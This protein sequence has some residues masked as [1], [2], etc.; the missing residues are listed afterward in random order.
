[1]K[2]TLPF[3]FLGCFLVY[4]IG[5]KA[6]VPDQKLLWN[7]GVTDGTSAEFALSPD[8]YKDFV[9]EGFGG[10]HRYYVVGESS[11]EKDFPYVLPGPRDDFG[12]YGYWAGLALNKLPVYFEL[13]KLPDTGTCTLQ[14]DII[15]TS[16]EQAP[17]LRSTINGTDYDHQLEKGTSQSPENR[18]DNLQRISLDLPVSLLREGIN[19]IVFQN[20]T[21]HWCAFDAIGFYGPETMQIGIPGRTLLHSVDFARR[22]LEKGGSQILPLQ[23][24]L[25]HSGKKA[26]IRAV[27][28]GA[29]RE[30]E[31]EAGHSV[32]EFEFPG[33]KNTRQS[34]VQIFVDGKL[35]YDVLRERRPQ[36]VVTPVDYV[37]QFMGTSGSRWM[38]APGP[39]MPMGMVKIAPDN[40]D[41]QWKA[42]YEY[43]IENVMGFSH[44]HE[45]TMA[46]LL[47]MP[48]NGPL[49]VQPGPADNPDLGY[50]SRINKKEEKAEI[51]KYRTILTDYGIEVEL[52][53]TTR[54]SMQRY[55]LPP[56][57][58]NRV[59]I[60]LHFPAEYVWELRDAEITRISD[61]LIEGW[62]YSYSKGTGYFGE[63]EYKLH[64]AIE[65]DRPMESM[66]GWVID[67]IIDEADKINKAS[68]E[69]SWQFRVGE[70]KIT[71]A[72]AF[73]RFPRGTEEVKIRTGISLVS[74]EQARLNL[75]EEMAKPFGWDFEAVVAN[76]KKAWNT[77]LSRVEIETD[78]YLQKKKFYTN[79]YRALSPRNTWSDVNGKWVDMDEK[80][81]QADP[82]RPL[83][84]SDG[85]WGWQWNLV[86]FYNLIAPEISSNWINTYLQMYDQGGWLPIGNP[87]LEYFR[88]MVGQ[89]EIPLIV[90]AYQ[91]G[92]RDFDI[93]K[94]YQALYH[95]QTAPMEVYPG[96]GQVGNE[97]YNYYLDRGYVPLNQDQHSYVSNTME[98]AYQDWCFAQYAKALGKEKVYSEFMGRSEN[99][100][101]IFDP[102]TGFVRPK[103]LDG[104]WYQDFSP[105]HAPGF[106]ESNSW[107]YTW[108]VPQNM[109]G[110]VE[111]MGRENFI[112]KLDDAM[113]LSEKVYFNALSDNFAAYPINHGNQSNM[114]S[115]YLFN[116]AEAPWLTQKWARAMQEKYYGLGPRD[117]Y[118]G[119]ED[120]GQMS[121]WFV[122]SALGLFQMDGGAAVE[123]YYELGSPRFKKV[124]LH[125]S[126]TYYGGNTF[127]IEA[128]NASR[129]NKYIRSAVLNGKKLNAWRFPQAELAKGGRLELEMSNTPK[130]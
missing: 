60:D 92:I 87:G 107:Q 126:D 8:R 47:M 50:R 109:S 70:M 105:F 68:Y 73:V 71:D 110:L 83:Y 4:V 108:Y 96:G 67:R 94:M 15:A 66:G 20:M 39:W 84:G 52:T 61:T 100:R 77:L 7:I 9:P 23:V 55:T 112:K 33:V 117:A 95:Q 10:A 29:A 5:I 121:S 69:P 27:V 93:D 35:K 2:R 59:L 42:G 116:H 86:Q 101:N 62:A 111:L 120:Q 119:D 22:E 12:G 3:V 97:S 124:T 89:P 80:V 48:A 128:R 49:F 41:S 82:S 21:G 38:I 130:K 65:F 28:D 115:C 123:P 6:Q 81:Q 64:F 46:G 102:T 54:A 106:C 56:D 125:L 72:G 88:V 85:Y 13:D 113:A 17:L 91:Q 34:Q 57:K 30:L 43:Q 18:Q 32:L 37:D 104:S 129:E 103:N 78:D 19:E 76:Q 45:W 118:P 26:T 122:M 24:D 16:S 31:M 51:G 36:P 53:A 79:M 114:Q 127:V 99:W 63:Q 90:S 75:E 1:M 40:E 58:E 44:V 98:Y 74:I 25:R 11:P 14:V